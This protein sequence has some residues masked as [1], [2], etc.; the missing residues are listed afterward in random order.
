MNCSSLASDNVIT[1]YELKN[2]GIAWK[3]V[4]AD[5][6]TSRLVYNIHNLMMCIPLQY[7]SP[8]LVS[9]DKQSSQLLPEESGTAQAVDSPSVPSLQIPKV[10]SSQLHLLWLVL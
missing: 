9:L 7:S 10:Q 3:T 8:S 4:G 2:G 6:E 5:T 1:A